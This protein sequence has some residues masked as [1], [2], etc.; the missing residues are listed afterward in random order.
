MNTDFFIFYM[1]V[2]LLITIA[3]IAVPFLVVGIRGFKTQR[4][5]LISLR[6]VSRTA[7]VFSVSLFLAAVILCFPLFN[8]PPKFIQKPTCPPFIRLRPSDKRV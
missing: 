4:P 6:W 5:F 2:S 8:S 3:V 7:L 1:K